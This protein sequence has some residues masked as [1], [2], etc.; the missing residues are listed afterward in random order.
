MSEEKTNSYYQSCQP[1]NDG[2]LSK[3]RLIIEL[4]RIKG[5]SYG[6]GTIVYHDDKILAYLEEDLEA[7]RVRH[8]YILVVSHNS[9]DED[10]FY[11]GDWWNEIEKHRAEIEKLVKNGWIRQSVENIDTVGSRPLA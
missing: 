4:C 7:L 9:A 8:N 3:I 6:G 5:V 11:D 1:C 10:V 2:G